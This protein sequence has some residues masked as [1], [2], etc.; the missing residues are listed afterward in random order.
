M[1]YFV[2]TASCYGTVLSLEVLF[3]VCGVGT[4]CPILLRIARGSCSL[5][6]LVT[7]NR[8]ICLMTS[9]PNK[10]LQKY[11]K[12]ALRH[13]TKQLTTGVFVALAFAEVGFYSSGSRQRGQAFSEHG[14]H[15]QAG[16]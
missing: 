16:G 4:F 7:E 8:F 14:N 5:T 15:R 6:S 13:L 2:P 1:L 12:S 11:Q 10:Y 9:G 3:M